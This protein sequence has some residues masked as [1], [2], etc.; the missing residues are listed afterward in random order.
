MQAVPCFSG[1][2]RLNLRAR[3]PAGTTPL[4]TSE[5]TLESIDSLRATLAPRLRHTPTVPLDALSAHTGAN[6]RA[7]FELWQVTGSFKARGALANCLQLDEAARAR[8]VTAVSAG[9]VSYTHLTL[10]TN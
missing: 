5:I 2:P 7:K 9:T 3:S 8:G 1:R 6:V 4:M 10:P